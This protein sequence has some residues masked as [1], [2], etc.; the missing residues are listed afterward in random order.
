MAKKRKFGGGGNTGMMRGPARADAAS[1]GPPR[2]YTMTAADYGEITPDLSSPP[3]ISAG[4]RGRGAMLNQ[5]PAKDFGPSKPAAAPKRAAPVLPKKVKKAASR[6]ADADED[7]MADLRAS[8]A[9]MKSATSDMTGATG[10][11]KDKAEDFADAGGMK[12]GGRVGGRGDGIAQR[13][14]TKGR[15]C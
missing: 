10:S 11:L 7:F 9:K 1:F 2:P 6:A 8:A 5:T 14:K 3:P 15:F 13:G 4:G 12:K